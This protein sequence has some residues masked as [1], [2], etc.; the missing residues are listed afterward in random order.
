MADPFDTPFGRMA[1]M[2]DPFEAAFWTVQLPAEQ[3]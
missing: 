1:P 3:D 2:A